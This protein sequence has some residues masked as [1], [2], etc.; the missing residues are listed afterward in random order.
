MSKHLPGTHKTKA[1]L[2]NKIFDIFFHVL[3][4]FIWEGKRYHYWLCEGFDQKDFIL[5]QLLFL[6]FKSNQCNNTI[7]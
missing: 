6:L 7:T 5:L 1:H 3:Y 4:V 2:E